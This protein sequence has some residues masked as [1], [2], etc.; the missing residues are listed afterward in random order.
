[1]EHSYCGLV[2]I[3][4]YC[5]E[6]LEHVIVDHILDLDLNPKSWRN[7]QDRTINIEGEYFHN[8]IHHVKCYYHNFDG[9]FCS[10]VYNFNI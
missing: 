6:G 4:G 1:M 10:C 3:V 2:P 9:F 5:R 7:Q 8:L